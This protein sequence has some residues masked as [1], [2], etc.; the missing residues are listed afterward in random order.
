[1]NLNING[2]YAAMGVQQGYNYSGS[3]G[4][5]LTSTSGFVNGK[6]TDLLKK[7]NI[8]TGLKEGKE[9]I[10]A[11]EENRKILASQIKERIKDLDENLIPEAKEG[12][13]TNLSTIGFAIGFALMMVLDIALS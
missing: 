1:M 6:Q 4:K 13:H 8:K 3:N 7:M 10:E 5:S 12:E 2:G 11:N 9:Y